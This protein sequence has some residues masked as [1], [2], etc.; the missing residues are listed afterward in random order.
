MFNTTNHQ[1]NAD[2]NHNNCIRNN[3]KLKTIFMSINNRMDIQHSDNKVSKYTYYESEIHNAAPT[4]S[5]TTEQTLYY[6][7]C[8]WF[9]KKKKQNI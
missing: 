3:P 6:S 1:V 9:N 7:L 8:I 2:E 4:Q 5:D